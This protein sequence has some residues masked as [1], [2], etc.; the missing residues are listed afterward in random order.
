MGRRN[1]GFLEL[2]TELP[3]WIGVTFSAISYIGLKLVLPAIQ[4]DAPFLKGVSQALSDMAETVAII[5]LIPA[6]I[7]AFNAWR[8]KVYLMISM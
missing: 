7:S 1:K 8:K 5:L 2:L 3:W 6:S 4:I